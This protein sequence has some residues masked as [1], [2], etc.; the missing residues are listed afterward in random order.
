[1]TDFLKLNGI[2]L[3]VLDG[4]MT[5]TIK[6]IGE[7][8]IAQDGTARSQV[9]TRKRVWSGRTPPMSQ[10]SA[11]AWMRYLNGEGHT[12]S[13]DSDMYTSGGIIGTLSGGAARDAGTFK[14]GTHSLKLAAGVSGCVWNVGLGV[15]SSGGTTKG[16]TFACW[17][18][19]GASWEH[20]VVTYNATTGTTAQYLGGTLVGA[21]SPSWLSVSSSGNVTLSNGT[22]TSIYYDDV[23]MFHFPVPST[24]PA[25]MAAL[26]TATANMPDLRTEGDLI[27]DGN[28]T[29]QGMA[30]TAQVVQAGLES[31]G[32]WTQNQ[33]QVEFTL[34]EV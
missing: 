19:N 24:W 32:T 11:E 18:H 16:W 4:S 26:T 28:R 2:P 31:S 27:P 34:T 1:M 9:R 10:A 25:Y 12:A 8:S 13:F 21:S 6:E 20:Y 30:L 33:E 7:R 29:V 22:G 5:K 3:P 23:N 17:R 15:E 14:Y